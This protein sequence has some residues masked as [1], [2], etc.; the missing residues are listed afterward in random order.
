[1]RTPSTLISGSIAPTTTL[2]ANPP[3]LVIR[4]KAA[5]TGRIAAESFKKNC[6][7]GLSK[8]EFKVFK[9]PVKVLKNSVG[10][11]NRCCFNLFT[12]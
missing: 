7:T 2:K 5:S 9:T 8:I 11:N 10:W 6:P 12:R 3:T 1:V 4:P